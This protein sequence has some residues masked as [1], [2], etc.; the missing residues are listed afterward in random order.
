MTASCGNTAS[1]SFN[2]CAIPIECA[3]PTALGRCE[4]IVLVCG[5]TKVCAQPKTLCRPPEIGSSADAAKD[6][7][8]SYKG[9]SPPACFL[10][11]MRKAPSR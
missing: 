5:G 1:A 10:R 2:R 9:V 8:M 7:A 11:W 6:N 3:A 4:A